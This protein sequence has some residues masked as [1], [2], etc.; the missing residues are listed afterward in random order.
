VSSQYGREGGFG[1][2]G[3]GVRVSVAGGT[4][5]H[6]R[7]MDLQACSAISRHARLPASAERGA[8]R[9]VPLLRHDLVRRL[10]AEFPSVEAR[11]G[12]APARTPALRRGAGCSPDGPGSFYLILSYPWMASASEPAEWCMAD[13]IVSNGG[14]ADVAGLREHLRAAADAGLRGVMAGRWVLA[15]THQPSCFP[16]R[17]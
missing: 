16:A 4:P 17:G 9:A 7:A 15:V 12:T 10:P 3:F 6:L 13:Q 8:P 5:A 11:P 2:C 1:V 14:V